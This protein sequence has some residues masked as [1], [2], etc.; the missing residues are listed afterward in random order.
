MSGEVSTNTDVLPRVSSSE[1]RRRRFFGF[2]GSQAPQSPVPSDPPRRGTPPEEPQPKI[3]AISLSVMRAPV[4]P[5]RT[6][7]RNFP[8]SRR[9]VLPILR[10]SPPPSP[11]PYE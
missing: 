8:S 4:W 7:E 6:A 5:S 10:L 9:R 2:F 1:Q 11:A 3:V